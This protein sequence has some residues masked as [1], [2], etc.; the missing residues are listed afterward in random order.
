MKARRL[1]EF[2]RRL[3]ECPTGQE[4]F[5]DYERLIIEIFVYLFSDS[6]GEPK[7]QSRTLDGKQRRDVLF[8]NR[9][10][11]RLWDRVFHRFA[12][13]FLIVDCKNHSDPV[14]GGVVTDVDKYAN[15]ALGRFILIVSRLGAEASAAST[16]IR[17][18]RDSNTVVLVLSDAQL[19]EMVERKERGQSPEDVIED[20]LDEL[21]M[22][23]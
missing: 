15:K 6:L 13:D 8:G 11:E 4:H 16:Q 18:Y 22:R 10:V 3:K 19:L 2:R 21:L 9:R 7:P 1:D 5:S 20:A 17:V 12:A 23:Y 14:D